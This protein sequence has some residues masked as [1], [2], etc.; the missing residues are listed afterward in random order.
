[1]ADDAAE[2]RERMAWFNEARC[3]IFIHWGLYS[4]PARGEWLRFA[5]RVP[6]DEYDR[7]ADQFSPQ[8]FDADAWVGLAQEAGARYMVL[9]TRH[10]DGFCLYD[11][12]VSDFTSVKRAA[13]RDFV[14]DYVEAC[15]RAGMKVGFYYSLLDW[16]FGGY[17][18]GEEMTPADRDAMVQQVHDQVRELLTNYGRVDVLWFDGG[19]LAPQFHG[20]DMAE[21]W[22]A[23]ELTAMARGLQP[24]IL[25]NNRSGLPEDFSTPEQKVE[26]AEAGRA[27]ETCMTIGDSCTWGY[28]RNNPNLKPTVQLLQY[29]VTAASG[30]GNY[31]LNCGPRADGT[32]RPEHASRL[33]EIGAWMRVNGE[34]IYGSERSPFGAQLLGAC[35]AKGDVAYLHV[36][37]WPGREA[38]IAGVKNKVK[39]ATLLATGLR[40]DIEQPGN[41]RM[42]LRG[43]PLDPPDAYDTVIKL[44][45]DGPPEAC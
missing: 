35:T 31:L 41:G 42:I 26:A 45:L 22:R 24:H 32:I 30:G 15:R 36:F 9:T 8:S 40:A 34:S 39:S 38:C 14:A 29:L 1:M 25:I 23:Q 18:P 28:C 33:R 5:E 10:H 6:L 21:F 17:I 16:R 11:S 4:I 13:G 2:R 7:L 3:G 20:Q 44:Q 12:Q 19:W 27:W 37:R 43:L